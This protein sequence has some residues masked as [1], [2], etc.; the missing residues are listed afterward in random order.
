LGI[1]MDKIR[2]INTDTDIKPWDVGVH[3]SRTSFVAGNSLLGAIKKLKKK[4]SEKAAQLLNENTKDLKYESGLIKSTKTEA[5]IQ[6]DKVIRAIHFKEPN[7]LCIE[8]YYY[9][10]SSSFQDKGFMG[11]VSGTYAFASQ[12]IEVEVDTVTGNVMVLDV[13]VAQDVGRVL[14][15]LGLAGQIEGGV[16]MGLGYALTEELIIEEGEVC[17]PSF[18][19]YK[20]P[21]ACDI[22]EIH[23][24]PIET[25]DEAGPYGSKGVGEAP[26]IPTAAA[27]ANAVSDALGVKIDELPITPE[28][29]LRALNESKN[30]LS[31]GA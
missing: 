23:F 14:N 11:N 31:I 3:A 22:P 21:T 20:L 6:I 26:L 5:S 19:D 27:I 17:N 9:E 24:Y 15:P 12:A 13:H 2:V 4:I 18:H 28:K 10:P 30:E 1:E 7:E 16:V 25:Y 8:S 29:V